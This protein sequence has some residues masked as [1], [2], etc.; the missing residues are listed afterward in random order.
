V[1]SRKT[2]DDNEENAPVLLTITRL[3]KLKRVAKSAVSRQVA[4]LEARNELKTLKVGR[5]KLV[6]AA[7]FEI[8]LAR[9]TNLTKQMNGRQSGNS[10]RRPPRL[11]LSGGGS[12]YADEQLRLTKL[13][14]DLAQLDRDEQIGT[15]VAVTKMHAAADKCSEVL[16]RQLEQ[17]VARSED[18]VAAAT[19]D[20]VRGL[21][22]W[23]N[24]EHRKYRERVTTEFM[25]FA[26]DR[27]DA[28]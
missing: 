1:A 2:K 17:I 3:A 12:N 11:P 24:E 10:G 27:S 25:V 20:G 26:A 15:L 13:K 5:E 21:R 9:N 16:I 23:L 18:G 22:S 6:D 19:R 7:A 4:R 14:A 8:A 28:E